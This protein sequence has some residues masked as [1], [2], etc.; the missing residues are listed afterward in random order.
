MTATDSAR[1][2]L[3]LELNDEARR[4]LTG[5]RRCLEGKEVR[6]KLY[7]APLYHLT[8]CFLGATPRPQIARIASL[9]DA[10][11]AE[12]FRLTLG[13]LNT[14]KNGS[15]LWAG[16]APCPALMR[17]QSRLSEALRKAGFPAE[18]SAYTPHITLGRQMKSVIP[19]L[20]VPPVCVEVSFMTLF[21]STRVDGRLSYV[22][23]Y[24]SVFR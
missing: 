19:E 11:P 2:F 12:P 16:V 1:L 7:D 14:F 18:E 20:T 8:L 21:E 17:L 6:G 5:V 10:T 24:R 4:A 3:G 9:M 15:I 22:P 13:R 23:L